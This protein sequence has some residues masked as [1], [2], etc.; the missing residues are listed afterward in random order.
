MATPPPRRSRRKPA[1]A[2][3]AHRDRWRF[4]LAFGIFLS[5]GAATVLL[6][7]PKLKQRAAQFKLSDITGV[8]Y[9][10]AFQ[11]PDQNGVVRSLRDFKGEVAVV[12]FG[13]T[14]CP[15]ACRTT[16]AE[17]A[18]AKKLLGARGAKLR[19]IFITVDPERDTSEV[20]QAFLANFDPSFVA[21]RPGPNQLEKV[22]GEFKTHVRKIPGATPGSCTI[23]HTAASFVFDPQGRLRLYAR[24]G[25]GAAALAADAQRLLGGA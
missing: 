15:E 4:A 5:A 7:Q 10:R 21:L 17:I 19:A 23:D 12:F 25:A 20:L 18:Q 9:G 3:S 16:M 1:T 6:V 2:P 8:D 13:F 14:Q 11:L 22:V 24:H